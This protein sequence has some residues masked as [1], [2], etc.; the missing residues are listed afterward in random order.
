MTTCPFCDF[1]DIEGSDAC[2]QCGQPLAPGLEKPQ[3]VL[4]RRL[5][6]TR[7]SELQPKAPVCVEP[8]ARVED[9]LR[10]MIAHSIGCVL[11][12]N[13]G[14]L[15]GIFSERDALLRIGNQIDSLRDRPISQFMTA[16]VDVL[17]PDAK[18]AFAVQ[19]MS[20]ANCRHI[21]IVDAGS[22]VGVIS[23][24]DVLDF[25]VV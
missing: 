2:A 3:G 18:L 21:P 25:L 7:I 24:R 12:V 8:T 5:L 15:A 1:E 9:V 14:Q 11:V 13:A 23:T 6:E 10:M 19:R 22:P 20:L 16:K 17:D 4:A